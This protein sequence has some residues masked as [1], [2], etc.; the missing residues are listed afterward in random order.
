MA[1]ELLVK[2]VLGLCVRAGEQLVEHID[3]LIDGVAVALPEKAD[4]RRA[5]AW[6]G[7]FAQ[8][9]YRRPRLRFECNGLLHLNRGLPGSAVYDLNTVRHPQFGL[10]QDIDQV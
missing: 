4:Q 8:P 9:S 5:A 1:A 10:L 7:E 2:L 6:L 3:R